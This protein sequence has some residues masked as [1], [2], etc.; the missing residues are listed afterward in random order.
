MDQLI[1]FASNNLLLAGVWVALVLMLIYT[2]I[3]TFT[4][5]IKEVNTHETTQLI[6]KQDAVVLDIRPEKD[7]K[8]GHILG[9]R[10]IKPEELRAKNFK[11]LE[12]VKGKPIIVVCAMGNS[13]R[14]VASSLNKAGF[15]DVKVLKGGINAWQ[16]AGLPVSK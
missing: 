12:N 2:Y 9:S 10:Q 14:G 7:F 5:G 15:D 1:E 6:N 16:N 8:L 3:N 11:K 4:S 13:A